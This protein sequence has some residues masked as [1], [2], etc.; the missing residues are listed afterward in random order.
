MRLRMGRFCRTTG[1]HV[2]APAKTKRV[3]DSRRER[4]QEERVAWIQ[5]V[6][7]FLDRLC[8][9]AAAVVASPA[10]EHKALHTCAC[11]G[12]AGELAYDCAY[13]AREIELGNMWR[14]DEVFGTFVIFLAKCVSQV[15]KCLACG[16]STS[17]P[18]LGD[19][20]QGCRTEYLGD[21]NSCWPYMAFAAAGGVL[22]R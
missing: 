8:W 3:H 4:R 12:S 20:P 21:H 6:P 13:D 2:A 17:S 10:G 11:A 16:H 15:S 19:L 1:Q 18:R 14:D 7:G 9:C 22:F 5:H